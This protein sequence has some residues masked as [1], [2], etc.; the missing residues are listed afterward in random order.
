MNDALERENACVKLGKLERHETRSVGSPPRR[1]ASRRNRYDKTV[2]NPM[3][4]PEI[5]NDGYTTVKLIVN[6]STIKRDMEQQINRVIQ[7][8]HSTGPKSLIFI[9]FSRS[10]RERRA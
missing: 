1:S 9:L 6:E 10:E 8:S 2:V 7:P 3:K 5:C 4:A